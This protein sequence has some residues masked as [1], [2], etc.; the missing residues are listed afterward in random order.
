MSMRRRGS[1]HTLHHTSQSV[2]D[3]LGGKVLRGNEVDEVFLPVLLLFPAIGQ[4]LVAQVCMF[5]GSHLFN[6]IED[7]GVGLAKVAGE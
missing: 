2:E 3:G 7:S 6:D 5:E 1:L 4:K